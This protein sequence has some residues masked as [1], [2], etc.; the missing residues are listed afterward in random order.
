MVSIISET[1]LSKEMSLNESAASTWTYEA[2]EI[3]TAIQEGIAVII[4]GVEFLSNHAKDVP[5]AG[6]NP[7]VIKNMILEEKY[8]SEPQPTDPNVIAQQRLAYWGDATDITL[9]LEQCFGLAIKSP[10]DIVNPAQ[11]YMTGREKVYIATVSTNA[12]TANQIRARMYYITVKLTTKE[13][14]M[15]GLR[16]AFEGD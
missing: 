3:P 7:E 8:T 12:G 9:I 13:I 4:L 15:I 10:S 1:I 11:G 2:V 6:V 14:A 5:P 16:E